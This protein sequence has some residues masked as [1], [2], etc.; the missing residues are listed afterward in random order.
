MSRTRMMKACN[1]IQ[2]IFKDE[3]LQL[4]VQYKYNSFLLAFFFFFAFCF[5]CTGGNVQYVVKYF[6]EI[7]FPNY[8]QIYWLA[9]SR[10]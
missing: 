2:N 7:H 4:S 3:K 10:T 9:N 6:W 5:W 1:I 8:L